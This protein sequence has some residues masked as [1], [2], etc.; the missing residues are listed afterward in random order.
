MTQQLRTLV[1]LSETQD[2]VPRTNT[3]KEERDLVLFSGIHGHQ[4]HM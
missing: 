4:A 1:T 2:S 3:E